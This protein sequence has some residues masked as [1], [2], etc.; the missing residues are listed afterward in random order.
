MQPPLPSRA[1]GK[2]FRVSGI[3]SG[4]RGCGLRRSPG[5]A[6]CPK[7]RGTTARPSQP[8]GEFPAYFHLTDQ[9]RAPNETLPPYSRA[10]AT[11]LHRLPGTES[12]VIVAE[13][14]RPGMAGTPHCSG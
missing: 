13:L 10:A 2:G 1:G 5:L 6:A 4:F 9:W 3:D 11:V 12:A 8:A 7:E 14:R